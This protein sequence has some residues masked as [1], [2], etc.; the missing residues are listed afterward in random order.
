MMKLIALVLGASVALSAA[1]AFANPPG[2][3]PP[4]D[5]E[6]YGSSDYSGDY[7]GGDYVDRRGQRERMREIRKRVKAQ[8]DADGDGR[9]S[10]QERRA[11]RDAI[12][13]RLAHQKQRAHKM[14][15][16][17]KLIR[18]L[19][20]DGDGVVGPGEAPAHIVKKLKRFDRNGDGWVDAQDFR[21]RGRG[22]R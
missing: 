4:V 20:R 21:R 22:V 19:D 5:D 17:Q 2:E 18:K 12:G 13:S 9:L 8:F 10:R 7:Y 11:A 15:K 16:L 1:P 6:S 14:K 3:T